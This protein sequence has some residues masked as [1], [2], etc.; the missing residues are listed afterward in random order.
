MKALRHILLLLICVLPLLNAGAAGMVA[1]ACAAA[2]PP[3]MTQQAATA[4]SQHAHAHGC[5]DVSCAQH[6]A[7]PP[8]L[9]LSVALPYLAAPLVPLQPALPHGI[10]LSPPLRPPLTV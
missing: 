6:C 10:T 2:M 4:S 1:P 7:L 5:Q 8:L 9:V 3:C